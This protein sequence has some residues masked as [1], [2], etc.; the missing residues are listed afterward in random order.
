MIIEQIDIYHVAMPLVYPW[1][2]AYGEDAAAESVLVQMHSQ[3]CSAWGESAPLAAPCYSPEWAGGVFALLRDWLAPALVGEDVVSGK[4]LQA[5]LAHFKG[6]PFAK[7]ALDTAWWVLAAT[8]A[9]QPLHVMLGA[10]RSAADVG[11]DFGVMDTIDELL[12]C[13]DQAVDA[14]F[15]RIK[16]K[17]RPGWDL[18]M[19]QAVR[20]RHPQAVIH[21]DLNSG[22]RLED[23][24][25]FRRLDDFN[26]AMLEQPLGHDDLVDHARLQAQIRT[27]ICLDESITSVQ[28]AKTAIELASCRYVN[29]KPGRVGGLTPALEIHD[30][31]QQAGIPC[32]VGG[33]LESA[34]GARI[35]AALA[36]L[37]NFTYPSDIF[38]SRRFYAQDLAEPE[39]ELEV[40]AE[41]S[42]QVRCLD[43]PGIG[44]A[45]HPRRLQQLTVAHATLTAKTR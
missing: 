38:P 14:G 42:P 21:I 39:L 28:R 23:L 30:L 22:Y 35:C 16:L 24:E 10:A 32:W 13:V 1:R 20:A 36:M 29:V 12:P 18:P 40:S 27:P 43:L 33:M 3:G 37:D 17:F 19:L 45:P 15:R 25:L 2:T 11:A 26:L 6:N 4:D 5:R 41:G 8:L 7:A 34:V 44:T 31:C 9:G